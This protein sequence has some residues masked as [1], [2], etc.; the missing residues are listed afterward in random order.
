MKS[1][2]KK[3]V[4]FFAVPLVI[5]LLL[6]LS[7]HDTESTEQF[8]GF[9]ITKYRRHYLLDIEDGGIGQYLG[10]KVCLS[11]P[12]LC[13]KGEWVLRDYPKH[14]EIASWMRICDSKTEKWRFFDRTSSNEIF[15][16]NCDAEALRCPKPPQSGSWFDSGNQSS[17]LVG[18]AKENLSTIRT[19][20][21]GT[22]GVTMREFP[23]LKG[24]AYGA[25]EVISEWFYGDKSAM[26]WIQCEKKKCDVYRVDF[27]TGQ[28]T[29]EATPCHYGD[30]L[31][32]VLVGDRPEIRIHSEAKSDEICRDAQGKP[33]YPLGPEPEPW[34]PPPPDAGADKAGVETLP[35]SVD[36]G[37]P[38][39][40][41]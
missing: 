9:T 23:S 41:P 1:E 31:T 15:C 33:A 17:E 32:F 37:K 30:L 16:N 25:G 13:F 24:V 5:F 26:V 38:S 40:V 8:D 14:F 18:Y 11:K 21:Y 2:T 28:S 39:E 4:G 19:F 10:E 7:P 6:A 3:L 29:Q 35:L 36:S 12:N 34:N 27:K 22:A 20:S